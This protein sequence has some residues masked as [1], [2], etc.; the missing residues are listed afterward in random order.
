M[1]LQAG[2]KIITGTATGLTPV[3]A[4]DVVTASFDGFHGVRHLNTYND[5]GLR[6]GPRLRFG[7]YNDEVVEAR[8]DT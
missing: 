1:L 8:F 2:M 5:E 7:P 6:L 4:G 3:V